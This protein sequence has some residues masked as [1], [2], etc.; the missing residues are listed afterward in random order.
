MDTACDKLARLHE[1]TR[2]LQR[3]RNF[4]RETESLLIVAEN[5]VLKTNHIKGPII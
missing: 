2:T 1:K 5:N 4:K 3:K